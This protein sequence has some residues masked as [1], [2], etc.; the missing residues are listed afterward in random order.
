MKNC[1]I[2]IVDNSIQLREALAYFFKKSGFTVFEAGDGKIAWEILKA[3]KIELI[4]SDIRMPELDGFTLLR[5]L[6][7]DDSL[8]H[9]P[10]IFVT[11][12]ADLSS[13]EAYQHGANDIFS[14]PFDPE[15][16]LA[17]A[18]EL[19]KPKVERWAG[20]DI[21]QADSYKQVI[22]LKANELLFSQQG[23]NINFGNSGFFVHCEQ[24]QPEEGELIRFEIEFSNGEIKKLNC[25][26]RVAWNRP[27]IDN[28]KTPGYGV[29]IV[30]LDSETSLSFIDKLEHSKVSAT[31]P[32]N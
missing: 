21:S 24:A 5:K 4:V 30:A 28:K 9:I 16:I 27:K 12:F 18:I 2:L 11:G 20:N 10:L 25:L 19:L 14:K 13:D 8:K 7:E 15:D 29:Q 22:N 32:A 26:G 23:Q 6:R 1:N 17:S 31:I 3:T